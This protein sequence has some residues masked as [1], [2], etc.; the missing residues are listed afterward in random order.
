[1]QSGTNLDQVSVDIKA[2]LTWLTVAIFSY[3]L[4][5]PSTGW[6]LTRSLSRGED[7]VKGYGVGK[8][9][10]VQVEAYQSQFAFLTVGRMP[11]R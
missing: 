3:F 11:E 4:L 5:S 7:M 10:Y 2:V 8:D 6:S 9:P 1:V